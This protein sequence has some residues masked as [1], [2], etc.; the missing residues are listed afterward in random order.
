MKKIFLLFTFLFLFTTLAAAERVL[1]VGDSITAQSN[2]D[3]GYAPIVR[4]A[5]AD[6]GVTD[7]TF[8]SL[9][10]SGQT[11]AGW[12]PV[13]E[14]SKTDLNVHGDRGDIL[15][16]QEFDQ[17]GDTLIVFLGMNDVLCPYV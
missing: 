8:V 16:K 1:V 17:G 10:W 7:V 3:W 2:A 12:I 15:F 9:G 6:A 13:V 11:V 14:R 4:K 5:L